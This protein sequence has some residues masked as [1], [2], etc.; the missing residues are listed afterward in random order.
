MLKRSLPPGAPLYRDF[1]AVDQGGTLKNGT[2]FCGPV[3]NQGNQ[4][5]CTGHEKATN[6]EWIERAY[7][8]S[9]AIF[10]PAFIY[11]CELIQS[12]DFPNDVGS[13]GEMGCL[14]VIKDGLCEE[15]VDPYNDTQINQPIAAQ[16]ANAALH[17]MG[18]YHGISDAMTAISCLS[19]QVPWPVG[20]GFQ[21]YESFESNEVAQ[22]GVMPIPGPDEQLLGGHQTA[23]CGGYDIGDLPTIRPKRCGPA[24]LVQNSW[25]RTWGLFGFFWMQLP[26]LN[27]QTT[28]VK[29]F[30][31]GKPWP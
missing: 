22:T 30:H 23:G 25:D 3:K 31:S 18:A 19:D 2:P 24:I 6:G 20:I 29:I 9:K 26:I 11:S 4:G 12:G 28:D 10:S 14:V 21:V 8:K 27:E 1:R 5:S 15:S 13:D 16:Y 7:L 17:K